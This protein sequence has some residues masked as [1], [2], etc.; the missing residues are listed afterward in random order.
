M[1]RLW[2]SA[3]KEII[4]CH[5]QIHSID[6]KLNI[7]KSDLCTKCKEIEMTFIGCIRSHS[8]KSVTADYMASISA[9]FN[10]VQGWL[11]MWLLFPYYD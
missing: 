1:F 9:C 6:Y 5:Y 7:L 10:Y 8:H 3:F 11:V 2:N 4:K